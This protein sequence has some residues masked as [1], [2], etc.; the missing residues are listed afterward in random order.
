MA[1]PTLHPHRT[2]SPQ[3]H[4]A[5]PCPLLSDRC[6]ILGLAH[7][8]A[9]PLNAT[10]S[11]PYYLFIPCSRR[12]LSFSFLTI[13]CSRA[14]PSLC[15]LADRLRPC[16]SGQ[17]RADASSASTLH[18]VVAGRRSSAFH[19]SRVPGG[20]EFLLSR[21]LR[22]RHVTAELRVRASLEVPRED[23]WLHVSLF[24][25]RRP[26]TFA[27][28]GLIASQPHLCERETEKE[29]TGRG[30]TTVGGGIPQ[31]GLSLLWE[32]CHWMM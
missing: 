11:P 21:S 22:L 24:M 8:F 29:G 6:P 13:C 17:P 12:L 1:Q 5:P 15:V 7:S 26:Q 16:L 30:G 2:L 10:L 14:L 3:P 27:F 20:G 25:D 9:N 18:S 31:A 19:P 32:R 23:M 28:Y 4:P